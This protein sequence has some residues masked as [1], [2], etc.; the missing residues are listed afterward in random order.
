[1]RARDNPFSTDR[2]LRVRY[3]LRGESWDS[4]LSR[5]AALKYR[6]AIVGP[7]GAG[8]T[9]L[10]EDLEPHLV[11]KGFE[12]VSLRLTRE[13]PRFEDGV[14]C[15]LRRRLACDTSSFL[16]VRSNSALGRGG[17]SN[18]SP[19]RR[20]GSSLLRIGVD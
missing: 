16:T 13:L 14:L 8:K 17:A 4:L 3:R 2:V 11:A 18:A 9:T 19:D 10:L 7:E 6:G 20:E 15:E 1:M 12:V 5:L